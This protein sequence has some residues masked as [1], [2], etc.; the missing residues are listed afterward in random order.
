M[1]GSYYVAG[2]TRPPH[3]GN[4]NI[5]P[6]VPSSIY[7]LDLGNGCNTCVLARPLSF[8]PSLDRSKRSREFTKTPLAHTRCVRLCLY[9][10]RGTHAMSAWPVKRTHTFT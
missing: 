2:M 9:T 1:W 8:Q 5:P 4:L 10:E 6:N 3:Q 7:I